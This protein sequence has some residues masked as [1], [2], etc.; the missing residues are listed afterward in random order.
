MVLLEG[1]ERELDDGLVIKHL[2]CAAGQINLASNAKSVG[3]A[4]IDLEL[5]GACAS[6]PQTDKLRTRS[7]NQDFQG[8]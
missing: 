3:A 1:I 7:N 5:E 4:E 8:G 2:F 6:H